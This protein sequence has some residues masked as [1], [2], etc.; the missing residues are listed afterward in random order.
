MTT[1]TATPGTI[2]S[3][4]PY[5]P[6]ALTL[7][8]TEA[9]E[10][11]NTTDASL[12]A[13]YSIRL[14]DLVGKAPSV[15]TTANPTSSDVVAFFQTATGL[16][17]SCSVANL[18]VPTGNMPSGGTAGQILAKNTAT[19]FDA[20]WFSANTFVAVDGTTLATSGSATSLVLAV[21]TIGSTQLGT[22]SVLAAN[23]AT[24]VVGAVQFRQ[25]AAKSIVGV[26]GTTGAANV[27]DIS[28]STTGDILQMA[29][30]GL[31]FGPV[32]AGILPGGTAGQIII[33]QNATTSALK[34][35]AV[36]LSISS[37]GT[38]TVTGLQGRGLSSV[39]PATSQTLQWSGASWVAATS[40]V[41][42]SWGLSTT[43]LGAISVSTTAPPS[44]LSMPINL[45]MTASILTGVLTISFLGAGGVTPTATSPIV[46][47]F[48][49]TNVT[50]A[51]PLWSAIT[52][53]LSM[54]TFTVG[55]SLGATS[56]TAFRLWVCMFYQNATSALP[57]L[58]NCSNSARIF[59]LN[60]SL[61]QTSVA[62]SATATSAGVF[63]SP[64]GT[65]AGNAPF[66]V[67]GYV[68]YNAGLTTAGTY[69]TAPT[70]LVVRSAGMKKPGDIVQIVDL[71][72]AIV[73]VSFTTTLTT[74]NVS[75][76]ITPTST[77]NL[78][79]YSAAVSYTNS[80]S[81]AVGTTQ[82]YRAGNA[83]GQ[84][85]RVSGSGSMMSVLGVDLP[86]T[87][88]AITYVLKGAANT[89]TVVIPAATGDGA[90]LILTERMG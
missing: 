63:Y 21:A 33:A 60:E 20:T 48:P 11:V 44:G 76:S 38:A 7:A 68:D 82:L 70:A 47:G 23:I 77:I 89:G 54:S 86:Q 83:I 28:A 61:L 26:A 27:A 73:T 42:A 1:A 8:G 34:T 19:N 6:G 88:S 24:N 67:V 43:S 10:I 72:S 5:Q 50:T 71:T 53:A 81:V 2:P 62:I 30:T 56:A 58:I 17:K 4:T 25:S 51:I 90:G 66:R 18:G 14:T 39:A 65:T 46:V 40:I 29:A 16:P 64:N 32:G 55:A 15:M 74:T 80:T 9:L 75:A 59:S 37:T 79:Q 84:I 41:S 45:S 36:D 87:T 3:L 52:T 22:V 13:S 31:F 35:V 78:I 69:S 57:A 49:N 85:A 12:A